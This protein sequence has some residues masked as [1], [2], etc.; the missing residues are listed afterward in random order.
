MTPRGAGC[1]G[2]PLVRFCEGQES[3]GVWETP[4]YSKRDVSRTGHQAGSNPLYSTTAEDYA[5]TQREVGAALKAAS[6][7]AGVFRN[8]S[9]APN[10]RATPRC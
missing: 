3:P 7:A 5:E 8:A 4:A 2:K 10:C 6:L 1:L 9:R